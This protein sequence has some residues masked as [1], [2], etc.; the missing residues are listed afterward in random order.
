MEPPRTAEGEERELLGVISPLHG[1]DPYR[2]LHGGVCNLADPL[3]QFN[4]L[5]P[6]LLRELFKE[7]S[8][9]AGLEPHPSAE[10]VLRHEPAEV[11]VCIGDGNPVA[12]AITDGPG[13]CP[14]AFGPH[15]E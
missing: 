5:Q 10:K 2:L 13:I 12:L 1:D 15:P 14:R 8:Q 7:P 3:C 9:V 4:G 11:E 6:R